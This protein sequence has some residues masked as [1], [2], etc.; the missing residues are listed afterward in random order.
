MERKTIFIT[1]AA[2]GIGRETARYFARQ[3][4]FVGIVDVNEDGLR[5]LETEIGSAGCHVCVM[6]VTDPESVQ[7]AVDSFAEKT[8]GRIHVLLNNAGILTFGFFEDV[9]LDRHLKTVDV[10]FKGCLICIYHALK[11]MKQ[12]PGATVINMSSASSLYGIPDL[13][14][15]SAT[16][17]ALSGL[18]EALDLELEKSGVSVCDIRPPYVNTPL[19][20]SNE[21]V[22]SIEKMEVKLEPEDIA[23][24]IWQAAHKHKLH[25]NV[26]STGFL[27]FLMWLLPFARRP[28]VKAL[29]LP[30]P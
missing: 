22:F 26:S 7:S 11:Y 21:A 27:K 6:D 29:T 9:D 30:K 8:G 1:G 25:W 17:H 23:E 10:N 5:Q 14:V 18:T 16:K 4:W 3:G 20:E 19:L 28:I 13:A 12:T 15:Y 2:S 24:K